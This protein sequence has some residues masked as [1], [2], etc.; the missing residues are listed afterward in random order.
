MKQKIFSD[1]VVSFFSVCAF[2]SLMFFA[3]F[4][5]KLWK[6]YDV[7]NVAESKIEK[8]LE[9]TQYE[10]TASEKALLDS[11]NPEFIINDGETLASVLDQA[12]LSNNEISSLI[13]AFSKKFNP[14]KLN[15]GTAIALKFETSASS[16]GD[17]ERSLMSMSVTI[18]NSK[19]IEVSRN[20]SGE[21]TAYEVI[22]PLVH[23]I[24]KKSSIIKNSFIATAL[25][26]SVPSSS[27][28]SMIRSFSYDVDFQRDIKKGNKL[29]V[30]IDKFY[31]PEGKL[32][33]SGD[34]LYASL[35]LADRRISIYKFTGP[36]GQISYY[37][38]KGENIKKEFLRTPINAARISSK[39]GIRH[40]PVLGYSR[41]HKGID[42]AAPVGTPILAAG[43]GVVSVVNNHY[44]GYGKYIRI[45]HN[46][47]Y[48]TVY[49]HASRFAKGIKPGVKVVQ[50]Q[51]IAYVGTT[52]ITSGPHL[53][54]EVLENGV[55]INPL[56]FKFSSRS[57]TLVGKDLQL[58]KQQ[59]NKINTILS[60]S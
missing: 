43:T 27:V 14:R 22:T 54:Y 6:G 40:H 46:T 21:F 30:V 48:S 56:K 47:T 36:E 12:N 41:M 5:Y 52:G 25:E 34:I 45:K 57:E 3:F 26:M 16:I 28:M 35:T 50:G 55:Q 7:G 29:E 33:H 42:F 9:D 31:T 39:F 8:V 2:I 18:S 4:A 60:K 10:A 23:H 11:S 49:G 19:R 51:V 17:R 38:E 58:F 15:I 13:S 44:S 53:H 24:E 20:P 1:T 59:K 37:N 32:S